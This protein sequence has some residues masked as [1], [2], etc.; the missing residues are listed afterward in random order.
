MFDF[1][2]ILHAIESKQIPSSFADLFGPIWD[3]SSSRF[4]TQESYTLDFKETIPLN[5]S[6]E[7][8]IGIVRLALALHNSYGGVI[9]FGVRTD[10]RILLASMKSSILKSSIAYCQTYP[11]QI[12][13]AL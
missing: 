6:D 13:T 4:N 11:I 7:Y 2:P 8:G 1:A 3:Q 5:F 12:F 10:L 9:V